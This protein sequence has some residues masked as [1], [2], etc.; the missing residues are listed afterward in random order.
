MPL[1]MCFFAQSSCSFFNAATVAVCGAR[2]EVATCVFGGGAE[3]AL[4]VEEA[5]GPGL[6]V[7]GG[8]EGGDG[9]VFNTAP[10]VPPRV[11]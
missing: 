5:T 2:G 1:D 10:R 11:L 8:F 9:G 6:V 7:T 3:I 4:A